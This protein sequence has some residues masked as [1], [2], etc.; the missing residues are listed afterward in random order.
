MSGPALRGKV[1]FVG[2][3][4]GAP[5]LLTLRGAAAIAAADVVVWASS[6][7]HPGVLDHARAGA[8]IVDSAAAPLEE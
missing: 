2:A 7:V 3:G 4:P 5:D 6:L 1:A 8:R